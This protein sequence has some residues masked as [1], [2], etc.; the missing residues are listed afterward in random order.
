[1]ICEL[2]GKSANEGFK[3]RLEGGVVSAC[4]G[5]AKLGEVVAAVRPQSKPKMQP[6]ARMPDE[7]RETAAEAEYELVDDYGA[8]LKS[9]REKHGWTQDDL[10]KMVNEPHSSIHRIELQKFEP[11]VEV[12]RKLEHKLGI[13]LLAVR[14]EVEVPKAKQG[15]KEV[16]LGDLVVVR[17][18]N[19]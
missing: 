1:M 17:K 19:K 3:I 13:R 6:A 8:K 15:S 11:P 9:A 5:C 18:R 7:P 12:V 10:G 2:C 4:P 14:E 16:T